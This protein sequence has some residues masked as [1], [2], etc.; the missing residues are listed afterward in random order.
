MKTWLLAAVFL[1]ITALA[2]P[3][4]APPDP[5]APFPPPAES[6]RAGPPPPGVLAPPMTRPDVDH[7]A[8]E[9]DAR[10]LWTVDTTL[11]QLDRAAAARDLRLLRWVDA[12]AQ[13]LLVEEVRESEREAERARLEAGRGNPWRLRQA[14][15][16]LSQVAQLDRS[17]RSP[18][19]RL[20]P[21][22]VAQRRAILVGLDRL[23][24]RERA[25]R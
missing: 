14:E 15:W 25:G 1:P 21:P 22:S 18:A 20:D 13:G 23:N 5:I 12:R 6:F 2:R 4:T 10:D 7:R 16:K 8:R 17:Y 9:D 3:W 24:R 19:W 11:T